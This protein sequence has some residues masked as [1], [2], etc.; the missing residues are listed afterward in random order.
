MAEEEKLPAGW[1]KRMSRSSGRVYYFNHITNA[2]QWER[3]TGN[4]KNGQGEPT[5]VRCSH[6]LVKHNQSRR[7]S[8]WREDKITRS[9]EE[10]LELI[11]GYIQKIKSGEED[12]ETL[13]SQFSDCSSAKAG[14]DLGAFGR[15]Q[16]QKPF[17]DASFALRTG[18]M[19]G[20][21]FTDSGIHII[22]RTE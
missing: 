15:G 13:A 19:S 9:K 22:L 8:S 3:P 21:V 7:P 5:K 18:E 4:S 12:F 17:E 20:P 6:L 11:N 14:G 2:S 10:A 1:E 16:M